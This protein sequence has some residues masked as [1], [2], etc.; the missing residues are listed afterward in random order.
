MGT[1]TWIPVYHE[2]AQK[3]NEYRDRQGELFDILLDMKN[4]GIQTIALADKGDND[5]NFPL[6]E[7]DPFTFI[8]NYNTAVK[9]EK[10]IEVIQHLKSLW[11]LHSDVPTDFDGLPT[12]TPLKAWFISYK[13]DRKNEDVPL[14]W[15]LF[16]QALDG[17]IREDT[18]NDILKIRGVKFNIT[19]G[20]FWIAPDRFLNLDSTNRE[21]L[22]QHGISIKEMPDYKT[23]ASIMEEAR[24]KF[25][26]PFFD[27]SYDAWLQKQTDK[28]NTTVEEMEENDINDGTRYWLYAPGPA[29]KLWDELY[30]QGIMAIGWDYLG[31]L[32]QYPTKEALLEAHRKYENN[33][34]GYNINNAT[35]CYDFFTRMK[36]GDHVYVKGGMHTLLGWGIV[37][38]E[39]IFDDAR[40]EYKHVRRV[41]WNTK[42]LWETA[43]NIRLVIKTL[44]DITRK[45][46]LVS[47]LQELLKSE[48]DPEEVRYWWLNANPKIWDFTSLEIGS[49]Q[50]YT[51]HNTQGNK[52][53]IYKHFQ[54]ATAGDLIIGY[55]SSPIRQIVALC[56]VT[57]GLHESE[58]GEVFEF[59]KT[60]QLN[61]PVNLEVLKSVPELK[62][63][64]PLLNNQGSLFA[65]KPE[66]YE[67]ISA[68]IEEHNIISPI[69]VAPD[70][71]IE[72]LM[73]DT[74]IPKPTL[75]RWKKAIEG[76]CQA[77]FFGPPGTGK[78]FIAEHL[79]RHL[80]GG[81]NGF[82]ECLQFHPAYT[83]EEFMQGIRPETDDQGNLRFILQ[84]GRFLE[85][86]AKARQRTGPCVLIIDELNRA[87]L[88]RVFGELMYLLEYRNSDIALAGGQRF[89]IPEN[90]VLLGTMNTAD[91]SIALVDFALRR[92]FAFIELSPEYDIL[93]NWLIKD[94][95][96]ATG[97]IGVLKDINNRIIDKH[98]FVGISFF[99]VED[100]RRRLEIIWTMEIETYLEEY[101]INQP[102]VADN[103][104]WERIKDRVLS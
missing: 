90:V 19:M 64:E 8:A 86:C 102:G 12:I 94:G 42:G 96:D 100:L 15:D 32:M 47:Y 60:V 25:Q 30:A 18:F 56:R 62:G 3:L 104:R 72:E 88:P 33:P 57:Q 77:V 26:K 54:D 10:R 68:V 40:S 99:M 80:I 58:A 11:N 61:T 89:S 65:L 13:R 23:Y 50:T 45:I 91:R 28:T 92:R 22:N 14:L 41:D 85:F 51:S 27:I 52:R 63:C 84:A 59:E 95:F 53:R 24:R 46:D 1:F 49:R 36:I 67:I 34:E 87:N 75:V 81:T 4:R 2:I 37:T 101:F 93:R 7:I 71:T 20:L 69:V 98:F 17:S 66:E 103:Y 31:N 5:A 79:A 48:K 16:I 73:T 82:L 6:S 35:A 38:S 9:P 70:Y 78:T 83:Y 97:L 29:A 76:K 74:G 21:Y 43:P 44:T 39:Y 55:V